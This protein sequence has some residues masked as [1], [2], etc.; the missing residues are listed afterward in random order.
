MAAAT[1]ME[2]QYGTGTMVSL[3][4]CSLFLL[5]T[6][7]MMIDL[8]FNLGTWQGVL[9]ITSPLMDPIANLFGS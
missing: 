1:V 4:F 7:L 5:A 3:A 9:P 2:A 6:G 8:L